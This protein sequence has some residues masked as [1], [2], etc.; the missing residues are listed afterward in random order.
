MAR[1][2]KPRDYTE[3]FMAGFVAMH[4]IEQQGVLVALKTLMLGCRKAREAQVLPEAQM[5]L[6][7]VGD[8][9]EASPV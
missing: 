4:E 7:E 3:A 5:P 6:L 1:K 2:E 9:G 8:G